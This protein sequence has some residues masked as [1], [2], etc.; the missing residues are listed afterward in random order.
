M[1]KR[2]EILISGYGGQGVVRIGQILG[3]AAVHQG[4]FTTMLISHGTETRGGYVRS[5]VVIADEFI[6]SPVV[7]RPD[8]FLAFSAIAYTM[9]KGL[10]GPESLIIHNPAI[11]AADPELAARHRPLAAESLAQQE[12]G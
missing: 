7:E 8:Y 1:S 2:I 4:L 12:L 9:F 6:A 11:V 3:E 5:Q 10:T